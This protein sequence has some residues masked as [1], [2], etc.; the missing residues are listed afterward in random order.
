MAGFLAEAALRD[1]ILI[2]IAI[3]L[4]VAWVVQ[5]LFFTVRY[6]SNLPR[7]GGKSRFSLRTRW[8]YHTDALGL[9]KEVYESYSKKGKTV[10]VP[11]LGFHDDVILPPTAL[12]WLQRQP[13]HLVSAAAA[14]NEVIQPYYGFGHD[15]FADDPWSGLLVKTDLNAVLENVCA[16]MNDELGL[17]I[18]SHFG[19]DTKAWKDV[20]LMPTIRLIVAQA[21]TRFT[22]GGS[23]AGRKLCR[24]EAY[25][26][27]CLDITDALVINAGLGSASPKLLRPLLGRLG[28]ISAKRQMKD[29][30]KYFEPVYRERMRILEEEAANP[31]MKTPEDHLQIMLRFALKERRDEALSLHDM[32]K[33]L[34]IANFGSM[35]QTTIQIVNML[36]N[37]LDS[38][39]E[40]NTISTL[41]D[42]VAR[43][44]GADKTAG[45]NKSR[46]AAM[47]RADSVA[48]E[49]L[50]LY[51]FGLRAVSR[52]VVG[53]GLVTDDGIALP[54]GSMVSFIAYWTQ[55]DGDTFSD[56]FKYDPF[57]FSRAREAE[58]D[59]QGKPGLTSL[60]FVSTGLQ[61]LAFSHGKH[62]CPGRFLVDFE[63][64]MII[65]H[66]LMNYDVE[67]PPEYNGKRP[68]NNWLTDACFPPQDV[69]VRVKRK[70]C[71]G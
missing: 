69:K 9:Y 28:G 26:K 4:A 7:I 47:M 49:T 43:V 20:H 42:E 8:R 66:V 52:K 46:V 65:A 3:L 54:K 58:M 62:A 17:A 68:Q 45:W 32:T 64:K 21:A 5:E 10:L 6:P 2:G 19:T 31:G 44:L 48:R 35:H 41:R 29:L 60:S 25:L 18:D 56:P 1:R 61:N 15:K 57:R 22:L 27:A 38:D 36:L 53:D 59:E 71:T 40:F 23:P 34:C 50:R 12:R 14:Q 37:I 24:N 16:A 51:A 13:E 67:F 63:L 39:A 70:E 11:G 55:T 30:E 33:R